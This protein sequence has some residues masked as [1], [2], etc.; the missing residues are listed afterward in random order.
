MAG[1]HVWVTRFSIVHARLESGYV[2][3]RYPGTGFRCCNPGAR[4][5]YTPSAAGR[6]GIACARVSYA[7]ARGAR[8]RAAVRVLLLGAQKDPEVPVQPFLEPHCRE[9]KVFTCTDPLYSKT[10]K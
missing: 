3:Q 8:R 9:N 5:P 2:Y 1:S 10:G 4:Y 6:R 7:R